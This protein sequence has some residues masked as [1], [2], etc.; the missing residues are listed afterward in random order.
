M[1]ISREGKSFIIKE[2]VVLLILQ[3]LSK[4]P[5][6]DV[7]MIINELQQMKAYEEEKKD[8]DNSRP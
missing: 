1:I 4:Q 8:A 7:F 2:G 5:Y 6:K 3:Y